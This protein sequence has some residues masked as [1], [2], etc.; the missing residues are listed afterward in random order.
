MKF[1]KKIELSHMYK[2]M[3][4]DFRLILLGGGTIGH[5]R[6][7]W[8]LVL[9]FLRA[10]VDVV[11]I[12]DCERTNGKDFERPFMDWPRAEAVEVFFAVSF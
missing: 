5:F 9:L 2:G 7:I 1:Q 3:Q 11:F 12:P 4:A 8:T 6:K 10:E